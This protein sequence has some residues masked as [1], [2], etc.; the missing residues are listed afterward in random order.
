[1]IGECL[2]HEESIQSSKVWQMP[3]MGQQTTQMAYTHKTYY[4]DINVLQTSVLGGTPHSAPI[5]HNSAIF[6]YFDFRN[7]S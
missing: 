4:I 7:T 6:K 1:M 2:G 5:W 3:T